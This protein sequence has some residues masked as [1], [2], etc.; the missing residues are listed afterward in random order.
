[1]DQALFAGFGIDGKKLADVVSDVVKNAGHGPAIEA[2]V[3]PLVQKKTPLE[4]E[5][6]N[7][8]TLGRTPTG[9]NLMSF[10]QTACEDRTGSHRRH[11]VARSSRPRRRSFGPETDRQRLTDPRA[12]QGASS[13]AG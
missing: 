6:F 10:Q 2:Y 13:F 8:E 7:C 11:D 3:K 12:P 4:L 5:R 9:E 1:M